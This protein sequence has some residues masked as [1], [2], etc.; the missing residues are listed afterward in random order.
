M[1][2]L[3]KTPGTCGELVQGIKGGQNFQITCPIDLFSTVILDFDLREKKDGFNRVSLLSKSELAFKK[4]FSYF[5][6]K[7]DELPV[8]ISTHLDIPPEKGMASSSA[9]IVGILSG[10]FY[11]FEGKIDMEKIARMALSIEPTDGIM[12]PEIVVFDYLQKGLIERLAPPHPSLLKILV[13]DPG[14]A[15]NTLAFNRRKDLSPIRSSYSKDT[16][17]AYRLVKEGLL[18]NDMN[19][20]GEGS[21][22]SALCNQKVLFKKDLEE[23]IDFSIHR[24]AVGVNV[25]HS[26]TVFGI[27][28]PPDYHSTEELKKGLQIIFGEDHSLIFYETRLV[29]GGSRI[30]RL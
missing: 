4:A 17:K 18:R 26:G 12:Y 16:E 8:R 1:K 21:I 25:A 13:V 28:L 9:D 3:I 15:V 29:A 14:G 23:V 27:L 11:H 6:V 2:L 24:G 7:K 20:L 30:E 19:L 5:H 22:L 10:I